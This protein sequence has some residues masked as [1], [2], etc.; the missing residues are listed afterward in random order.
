MQPRARCLMLLLTGLL[1]LAGCDKPVEIA[2]DVRPVRVIQVAPAATKNIVTFSGEVRARAEARLGFRVAGK[3]I[4]RRV[5]I[6]SVIKTG[7]V[8]AQLDPRDLQLAEAAAKALL[9][10][11]R[12][13]R[14]LARAELKRYTELRSR[15]FISGAELER[16]QSVLKAA[17]ARTEQA[18]AQFNQQGNQSG[19][20]ILRAEADGVVTAI[21]AEPGQVLG[22]GQTVVRVAQGSAK[23]V[24][25]GIPEHQVSTLR[26]IAEVEVRLW[27]RPDSLLTGRIREIS[28]IAD[29]ATRTY[30]ARVALDQPPADVLLGMTASVS[31]RLR[32][33]DSQVSIPLRALVQENGS[34]AVWVVDPQSMTVS[35]VP[36]TVNGSAGNEVLVGQSVTPGSWVVT[37]GVHKLRPGQKVT[38]LP[39][40]PREGAQ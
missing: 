12:N 13:D 30:V 1:A 14:D 35:L 36:I 24:V 8:L 26:R 20:A 11:A 10:G 5:E 23:D 15:G 38:M 34:S 39:V 4:D 18:E 2:E 16:R 29:P 28:P 17:E 9:E 7:Q 27:A 31:F 21:E 6:G 3:L 25:F 19:Y 33:A 37:A 40:A 22:A 32:S